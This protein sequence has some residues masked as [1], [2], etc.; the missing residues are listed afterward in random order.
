MNS[1]LLLLPLLLLGERKEEGEGKRNI[2]SSLPFSP[3]MQEPTT[4]YHSTL[5]RGRRRRRRENESGEKGRGLTQIGDDTTFK[6]IIFH[7]RFNVCMCF[8]TFSLKILLNPSLKIRA[9]AKQEVERR[10]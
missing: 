10:Q 4:T 2:P 9:G 3:D 1:L 8:A 7:K 6:H 5:M